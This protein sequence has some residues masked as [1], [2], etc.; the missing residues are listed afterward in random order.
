MQ[1]LVIAGARGDD[2]QEPPSSPGARPPG[3]PE[4][5]FRRGGVHRGD[6]DHLA[7]TEGGGGGFERVRDHQR[8]DPLAHGFGGLGGGDGELRVRAEQPG[9]RAQRR[10]LRRREMGRT[11]EASRM[12]RP[13]RGMSS[14]VIARDV[15]I[16]TCRRVEMLPSVLGT[17]TGIRASAVRS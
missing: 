4:E 6:P 5:V 8:V 16:G 12:Y 2:P 9:A 10:R 7:A 3:Q 13:A 1:D 11:S 14:P 15:P 17:K